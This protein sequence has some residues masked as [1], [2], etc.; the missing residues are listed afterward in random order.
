VWS[1][2]PGRVQYVSAAAST[3]HGGSSTTTW[4]SLRGH[5]GPDRGAMM[6]MHG[7]MQRMG[8]MMKRMAVQIPAGS[9]TPEQAKQLSETMAHMADM[10]EEF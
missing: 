8:E 1:G 5:A 2:G 7:K 9:L 4:M 10:L 6:Q 3:A